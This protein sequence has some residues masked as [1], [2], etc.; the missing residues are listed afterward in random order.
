VLDKI[1][2]AANTEDTF[3]LCVFTRVQLLL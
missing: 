3:K 2:A 1:A